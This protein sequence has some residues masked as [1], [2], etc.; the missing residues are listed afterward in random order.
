MS[1]YSYALLEALAD[2]ERLIEITSY[3]ELLA[4]PFFRSEIDVSLVKL[5]RIIGWYKLKETIKC[6]KSDCHKNHNEGYLVELDNGLEA[7]IGNCCGRKAF[8][9]FGR[10][11]N[12]F[13]SRKR[14][15][16]YRERLVFFKSSLNS[17]YCRLSEL[18][19]RDNGASWLQERTEAFRQGCPVELVQILRARAQR[20]EDEV[21]V[22]RRETDEE[23]A[24]RSAMSHRTKDEDEDEDGEFARSGRTSRIEYV[25]ELIGRV[26]GLDIWKKN[27]RV[28]LVERIEQRANEFSTEDIYQLSEAKLRIWVSWAEGVESSINEIEALLMEGSAFF[29]ECNILLVLQLP[30]S[31][32]TKVE[33]SRVNWDAKKCRWNRRR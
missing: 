1:S 13:E 6:A 20:G 11:K 33:L 32:S 12:E 10:L 21:Y 7:N 19:K 27:I 15:S 31:A 14:I 23:A 29:Q 17:L 25:R 18:K 8:P 5:L 9:E 2:A 22:A 26:Q 30:I 16:N 28:L 24:L 3:D 4:R